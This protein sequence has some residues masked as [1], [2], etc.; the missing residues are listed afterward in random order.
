M[1]LA[2]ASVSASS[3]SSSRPSAHFISRTILITFWTTGSTA[4]WSAERDTLSLRLSLSAS[5][6]HDCGGCPEDEEEC[7]INWLWSFPA[8]PLVQMQEGA[9][10]FYGFEGQ[11]A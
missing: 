7:S 4:L 10:K 1:A 11:D 9:D 2:R 5:K 8:Y 6:S 3:M